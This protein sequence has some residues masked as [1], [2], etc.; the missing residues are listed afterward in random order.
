MH[1]LGL[2]TEGRAIKLPEPGGREVPQ[3]KLTFELAA[4]LAQYQ[5]ALAGGQVP[6]WFPVPGSVRHGRTELR[7]AAAHRLSISGMMGVASAS[8]E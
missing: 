5:Q 7:Q 4:A 2:G 6:L 3:G 1:E 8:P